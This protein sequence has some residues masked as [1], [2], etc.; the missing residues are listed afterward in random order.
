MITNA[1]GELRAS[2]GDELLRIV[3]AN[4]ATFGIEDDG[5]RD[6][7]AKQRT[8]AGLIEARDAR[9]A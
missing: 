2:L 4:N 7:W 8:A 1:F 3:Q 9:P 5:G 6:D